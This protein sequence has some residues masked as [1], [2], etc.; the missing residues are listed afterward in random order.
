MG[1]LVSRG[2]SIT[3]VD[4]TGN[5]VLMI[6]VGNGQTLAAVGC[7]SRVQLSMQSMSMPTLLCTL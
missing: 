1:L 4:N 2:L 3:A 7:Y 5:T 6:A